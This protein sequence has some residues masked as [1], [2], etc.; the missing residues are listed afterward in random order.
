M[1]KAVFDELKARPRTTSPSASSTTSRTCRC[2]WI[3]AST[4]SR[5][6]WCAR[7]LRPRRRRHGRRQQELD[8]DHRRGDRQLR[9]GL[10]RLRLEEVGRGHDLA[11]ALRPRPI[12]STYLIQ[13]ANFVAC[14]QFVFLEKYDVLVRRA[15]RRVPAELAP[16]G[17]TRSGT[18]C[19]ARC[20]SRSSRRSCVLRDRRL[21]GGRETGHG[22]A[23]QHDH[24]DLLL[25]DLGVLPR[26][27]AIARSRRR[28]R[29]PTASAARRSCRRTS[30]RSTHAGAPARG[31]VPAAV[32]ATRSHAAGRPDEAPDFVKRVTAVMMAGKGDL[33]PV[34][35]FPVDGT[36]P[37]RHDPVGEA[38]HRA[39]D[40]GLGRGALHPVQQVRDGLP[41]RAIRAKV[42][43]PDGS[44]RAG[45]VQVDWTSRAPSSRA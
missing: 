41:A 20:S 30:P 21:R 31:E 4:S 43:E 28:S 3:R 13:Q 19:R 26:D 2:R 37:V 22:R 16:T 36:W 9:A 12:R 39:R 35:A 34:S 11:P 15:G 40:P 8:Q 23:H 24:A 6:T 33:L 32:T 5:T 27:E 25:R 7:V 14:H 18:T 38:Q 29:R 17:R 45:D 44:R 10:L 42:Y 1:V